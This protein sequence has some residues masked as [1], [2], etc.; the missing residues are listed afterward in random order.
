M[1][2]NKRESLIF[3][4]L[5][6]FVMVFWM[7]LYN[8]SLQTKEIS[9]QVLEKAWLGL[10]FAYF[11]AICSDWFFVSKLAKSCAFRFFLNPTST[12]LKKALVISTCM[13]IPMVIIMSLYGAFEACIHLNNWS[14]L[15]IIWLWNIPTNFIMALPFQLLIA[16]PFVRYVFRKNFPE[17]CITA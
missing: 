1:P 6:C 16:G 4:I 2:K 3:T 12:E 7:S 11:I 9:L 13:V 15:P 17:G 10:P 8:I 5:M 14:K